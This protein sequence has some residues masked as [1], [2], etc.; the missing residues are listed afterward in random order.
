MVPMSHLSFGRK[1]I[2]A[3]VTIPQLFSPTTQRFR[4]SRWR[5]AVYVGAI[6]VIFKF[7][8]L[9]LSGGAAGLSWGNLV[10]RIVT[11]GIV[12]AVLVLLLPIRVHDIELMDHQLVGPV[13]VGPVH[14]SWL[15]FR[16]I[17]VPVS[18]IDIQGS[19]CSVWTRSF[20]RTTDGR[21]MILNVSFLGA[22]NVR[23]VFEEIRKRQ[24]QLGDHEMRPES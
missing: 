17:V 22:R 2:M 21:K 13:V 14:V 24:E 23:R 4:A 12:L 19:R 11:V 5:F 10:E 9:L 18:H 8:E 7:L 1:D 15:S 6:V 3:T 20:L 16:R